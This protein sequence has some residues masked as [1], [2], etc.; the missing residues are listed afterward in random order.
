ME[1]EGL[2]AYTSAKNMLAELTFDTLHLW[3]QQCPSDNVLLSVWDSGKCPL[4]IIMRE[5]L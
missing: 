2:A 1:R 3:D 4:E 5:C